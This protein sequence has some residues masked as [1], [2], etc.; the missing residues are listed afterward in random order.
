VPLIPYSGQ[1]L[2]S[3]WKRA[4]VRISS[5]WPTPVPVPPALDALTLSSQCVFVIELFAQ[6]VDRTAPPT[7]YGFSLA[8]GWAFARYFGAVAAIPDFSL[9]RPWDDI[10]T[11]QKTILSDDWG[12]GVAGLIATSVFEPAA[13]ANTGEWLRHSGTNRNRDA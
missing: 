2:T 12:V 8:E 3:F 4:D 10:D 5:A 1:A 11:H 13:I 9:S 7:G 6:I